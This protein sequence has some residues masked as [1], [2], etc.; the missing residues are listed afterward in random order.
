LG[1]AYIYGFKHAMQ[2]MGPDIVMEM[3][4]DFQHN[5]NDIPKFITKIEEGYDYVI[6]SRFIKGG[7]IPKEWGFSRKLWSVGGNIF[8][9]LVLGIFSVSDFTSGYK[10][11]RV[12]NYLD[13][14]DLDSVR[15]KGFAYKIDL[16]Y[17]MY[18][19][20]AKIAEVPIEF[21][22]RDR[23]DSKMECNNASDS[24][25]VVVSI[26]IN[27]NQEFFKFLCAGMAGLATDSGLFNILRVTI[28]NSALSAVISG[29]IAM[30][31]TF[32]INNIWSFGKRK[33][34]GMLKL[35]GTFSIYST[36]SIIPILLRS[37]L[38]DLFVNTFGDNFLVANIGF[39]IGVLIGL[40]WNYFIYSKIIWRKKN[41]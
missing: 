11:S 8:S 13:R 17:K 23:G 34:N 24:L 28:L 1:A 9:K 18:K 10:A 39:I 7:S 5:P 12:K 35:I 31:V 26:R 3:D 4:A 40:V 22:L 25:K 38:V 27:E 37:K 21:G 19:L 30:A 2:N 41:K 16:L 6:G 15:S 14:L 32:T 20:N 29:F 36:L 33:I